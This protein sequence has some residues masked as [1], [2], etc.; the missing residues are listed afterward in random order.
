MAL[1]NKPLALLNN[2]R[3]LQ[4]A[5]WGIFIHSFRKV[6]D[7]LKKIILS[8]IF[9]ASTLVTAQINLDL[10]LA[11]SH[12]QAQQEATGSVVVNE[13]EATSVVFNGLESLII[14]FITHV[15]DDIV[16]IQA[17]FLQ[18][19][20]NEELL[21]IADWLVAQVQLDEPATFT[22]NEEDGS[23]ELV[24]VVVPSAVQ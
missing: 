3:K 23:G 13:D 14:D 15:E 6:K 21:P 16:T 11:I 22:I 12:E 18:R 8:T 20:E 5:K 1:F 10:N 24:L 7:M 4:Q 2:C 9:A 17:Q 19:M